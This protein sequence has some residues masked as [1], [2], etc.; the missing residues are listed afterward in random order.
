MKFRHTIFSLIAA[1]ALNV[2]AQSL[3]PEIRFTDQPVISLS[4]N[5]KWA[6]SVKASETDGSLAAAGGCIYNVETGA[7]TDISDSSGLSEPGDITDDGA[8]VVG[9][10]AGVP[11]FWNKESGKWTALPL[12]VTVG[13]QYKQGHLLSVTPDGHFAVGYV[14]PPS[15]NWGAYPVMYDLTTKTVIPTPN[16]P[17][18]DMQ[19]EN[20][21]QNCF[22][23]ISADGRYIM[24]SLSLS[25][26]MPPGLCIYVYDRQT[27][28]YRF[29]GFDPS[30]TKPWSPKW[31]N[32]YFCSDASMSPDGHWVTGEAYLVDN[33][34]GSDFPVE[35]HNSFVYNVEKDEITVYDGENDS[36][37]VGMSVLN[38]G[39]ALGITPS[40]NPYAGCVVRSGN[41]YIPLEQ[42]FSQV[43]GIN[44]EQSYG[45]S[46]TGRPF[47]ISS[48]GRTLL[49]N[50]ANEASYF[51]LM[52]EDI[53]SAAAKVNLLSE[54][55]AKP[56][57]GS[58]MTN[59]TEV[60][61]SFGRNVEVNSSS[62]EI[63]L[64]SEDGTEKYSP[65]AN[66]GFVA[67]G[68][69]IRIT[70]RK[71]TLRKDVGYTLTLPAGIIR[72]KGDNKTTN[73]EIKLT[74]T[75][76]GTE[77]VRIVSSSPADGDA[78]SAID[79]SA[80]PLIVT[81]DADINLGESP[82]AKLYRAGEDT[83]YCD[84]NV[85]YQDRRIQLYPVTTQHLFSGTDYKVV[86]PAG[87]VTD[88]S[89]EGANEEI[90]L[91]F[92]GAYVREISA[93]DKY[94]FRSDCAD[95]DSFIFYE[96]DHLPPVSEVAGW[97]F[98]KDTPW[99]IVRSSTQTSD[100]AMAAHSMFTT[101]GTSDDWMSTPQ[102]FIPD[103]DCFLNF[104]VQSYRKSATD[105]LKVYVYTSGNVY[106]SFNSAIVSDIRTN[107]DLIFDQVLSPG[108][109]EVA[110]EGDW[111]NV[112]IPLAE[113]AGKD[114]YIVFVNENTDGSAVFLDNITVLHDLSFLT[115]F[116]HRQR[117]VGLTD[118]TIAGN[119][120]IAS[121]VETFDSVT[122][123]LRDADGSEID[124]IADTGLSL[125]K[126]DLF[127]FE[128]TNKLPLTIG[129]INSFSVD[130]DLVT[131]KST[132]Q[133]QIRDLS[134]EPTKRFVLEEYSG[135]TCGNC[136][137]GIV[138]M[139]NL[140]KLY[141]GLILP[142]LI[143]TYGS[144][145]LGSGLGSYQSALE[146]SAAPTAVINRSITSAPMVSVDGDYRFSGEGLGEGFSTWLDD[147]R[148]LMAEPADA[149]LS[150][151]SVYNEATKTI[152]VN[153]EM[154]T[155]LN[156]RNTP[157]NLF[158]V[159]TENGLS[160]RQ[161]NYMSGIE[162]PDLGEWGKGGKY[163]SSHVFGY[164]INDVARG[165][166]GDTFNGTGGLLPSTMTAGESY[167]ASLSFKL[168]D[169]VS[170]PENCDIT[171]M[172]IDPGKKNVINVNRA[173]VNGHTS[174]I[175]QNVSSANAP[176]ITAVPGGIAVAAEGKVTVSVYAPDG[177]LLATGA[178]N[179][180][181]IRIGLNGYTGIVIVAA[182]AGNNSTTEKTVVR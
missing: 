21:L 12:P 110:L 163:G 121:D 79:L 114:V 86:I 159:V 70:F 94:L 10:A 80:N 157:V 162:D 5:G 160:T 102:L 81:F 23:A 109:S 133:G 15:F 4:D 131:R 103:T 1:S 72:L 146:L 169:A 154:R 76:R 57:D 113:Y 42:I 51:V 120:T 9:S 128:F 18:L 58:R 49:M 123:I 101:G 31:N 129:E 11:A 132:I 127:R 75:G 67:D 38:D 176:V 19:H 170:N 172:L 40:G 134:F 90:T 83:P 37:I 104:D 77:P 87:T 50:I 84:L 34:K 97:G 3:V 52:K 69:N 144:D 137:L 92:K 178:S 68:K 153:V 164:I 107:G 181:N 98:T 139:E 152:S 119:I 82:L 55:T 27:E 177:T 141:P 106:N 24:G 36:D 26:L 47:G 124:R 142:V 100:M 2:S 6:I 126:G 44:F 118:I 116:E 28:Q 54:W 45:Q 165:V 74:F 112:N 46:T 122:L 61:L 56:A 174:G 182:T 111:Q 22:H 65:L 155:A 115:T 66:N 143:R 25:Y 16:L 71:R 48:D 14:V 173:P 150:F 8:I 145:P 179:E 167:K 156:T 20:N 135:A 130:A 33:S 64:T 136:P 29:I 175:E 148:D 60:R 43:Y 161:D 166:H 149:D 147:V 93:D 88:L 125:K 35:S 30:D 99:L 63:T 117:V 91:N 59:V 105:R 140:E 168:P 17:V 32:L 158:A 13:D 138:A 39:T 73:S 108:E 7:V 85:L 62:S 180:G 151:S 171:V 53:T 96:G 95:Y 89:G 78:V 41:Y